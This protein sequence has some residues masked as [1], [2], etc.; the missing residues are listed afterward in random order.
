MST[1]IASS[2]VARY[3][4]WQRH[5][6]GVSEYRVR[7]TYKMLY[8][9]GAF[10]GCSTEEATG[11]DF[12]RWMMSLSASGL[13]CNTVRKKGHMVRPFFA[14]AKREGLINADR[15]FEIR[16]VPNPRGSTGDSVPRPYTPK[17]IAKLWADLDR[18]YPRAPNY[19]KRY[20][21]G[22]S[23][24]RKIWRHAMGLQINAIA[25]L[26]LHAGMRREESFLLPLD[27]LHHDNAYI[28]FTGAAKGEGPPK[29]RE[30]PMTA[31]L[32]AAVSEWLAMRTLLEPEHDRPWLVLNPRAN[33]NSTMPSSPTAP[34]SFRRYAVLF[35]TLGAGWEFHR[36]RHTYATEMLRAGMPLENLKELLGHATIQ[37]TLAYAKIV[38]QDN[39]RHVQRV[40]ASFSRALARNPEA[41]VMGIS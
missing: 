25:H 20:L 8:D 1:I 27:S 17:E 23:R 33:P 26:C 14:W 32:R 16:E 29:Q 31:E 19:L 30:V 13:H 7:E 34:M 11:K 37:Q 36:L 21:A 6:N 18:Q 4:D 3:C 41:D 40:E 5:Y 15:L 28:V 39:E 10:A 2:A 38:P 22:R 35:T 9:L 24:Y 12:E